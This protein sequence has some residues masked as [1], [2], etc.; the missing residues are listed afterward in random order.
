[1][2]SRNYK[3]YQ[4]N[5]KDL[6]DQ[7]GDCVVRALTKVMSK[8]WMQVFDDLISYAKKLQCMPNGKQCYESYLKENGFTY[9]GISNKKGSKRPTVDRFAKDHKS[10]IFFLN[11]ANHCIAVV[12]GYKTILFPDM[13]IAKDYYHKRK[14]VR[15][16][17]SGVK[18]E[19]YTLDELKEIQKILGVQV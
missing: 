6:K 11:V 15:F 4:P 19:S 3:Y 14:L 8:T 5:D 13:E 1:M 10:G 17:A 18:W 7:Y 2:A 12:D 9:H 16:L